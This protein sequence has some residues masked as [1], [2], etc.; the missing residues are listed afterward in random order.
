M[1]SCFLLFLQGVQGREIVLLNSVM[2][3]HELVDVFLQF[4]E[5]PHNLLDLVLETL[6]QPLDPFE[7]LIQLSLDQRLGVLGL[8]YVF[9]VTLHGG[10]GAVLI[11]SSVDEDSTALSYRFTTL[12]LLVGH[13]TKPLHAPSAIFVFIKSRRAAEDPRE[14]VI[15]SF[16]F[17]RLEPAELRPLTRATPVSVLELSRRIRDIVVDER[18]FLSMGSMTREDMT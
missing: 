12:E 18:F 14:L 10:K 7:L 11:G 17:V 8:E 16:L 5:L 1:G 2:L 6:Y 9:L 4:V 13:A 3:Q 15:F